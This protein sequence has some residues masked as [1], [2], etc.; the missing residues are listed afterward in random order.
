[1]IK[2]GDTLY[3]RALL[4]FCAPQ[5]FK[6]KNRCVIRILSRRLN[7]QPYR[8]S[9][10]FEI[11]RLWIKTCVNLRFSLRSGV[12]QNLL[13]F[14]IIAVIKIALRFAVIT[15][16][17]RHSRIIAV[18]KIALRFAVTEVS[19]FLLCSSM[20]LILGRIESN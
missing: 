6:K 14:R 17:I 19:I 7:P 11:N 12:N 13:L 3:S 20:W 15:L 18:I 2:G 1:M 8:E 5:P 10:G 9:T 16:V 4:S